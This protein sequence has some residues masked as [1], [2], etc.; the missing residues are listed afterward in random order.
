MSTNFSSPDFLALKKNLKKDFSGFTTYKVA[1]LGDSSTQ[2]VNNAIRGYG[3]EVGLNI[4]IY[5]SDY[6]QIDQ[7][8]YNTSSGLYSFKPDCILIFHSTQKLRSSFYKCNEVEKK[9]FA[10]SHINTINSAFDKIKTELKAKIIYFNFIEVN[11]A[12][13][14]NY[15]NK[16][17]SSFIFQLRKINFELMQLAI[18]H[19]NVFI[20]DI[21]SLNN[22]LGTGQSHDPKLYVNGDFVFSLDFTAY[23]AKNTVDIILSLQGK[24]KK[25]LILDLDN[26]MWGGVIGDDGMENIQIGDLGV[27]KAF[28]QLQAWIKQ[29]KQRGIILA[30]C[31]KNTES[32]AKEPFETHPDMVLK[33]DDISIFVANWE[34]KVDNIR[35]IQSVLNIGF[36]SMVFLDDNPFERELI[37]K[38]I[39]AVTVPDLPEDP[40]RYLG[41]LQ[42]LNLFETASFT[43]EDSER[44]K[45]Y[46]EEAKRVVFRQ[47]HTSEEDYLA[48]LGMNSEVKSFDKFTT[49]RV[50]QLTQRSNQFNVRTVR[51]TEQDITNM[52]TAPD[53]LTFSFDLKDKFGDHGL[54]A[55]LILKQQQDALFIDT[56]VMSCRVLKR[57]MEQFII[58]E[59]VIGAQSKNIN[60]I[61]GEYLPTSKNVIVKD[62]YSSLNFHNNNNLWVLNT[63]DFTPF[64][65]YINATN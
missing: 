35:Y 36:D 3:Y 31:S 55:A 40:S 27:G 34:S 54:I 63:T 7:E 33:L 10:E 25:C 65:T 30:V 15:G 44:T 41:F 6:A 1:I 45:Q 52:I 2:L 59:I 46:Q 9:Q 4:E 60:T 57:G 39:P 16:V 13:F 17:P 37:K 23:V 29:L 64:K 12:V 53:Y 18:S 26:T 56:W 8:I 28:S 58:N 11:D 48:S 20:N 32:I 49:P 51:Y 21:C 50:A 62:L 43:E 47:S 38:E 61:I 22:Q 42:S 14:G 5:E 19:K 24:I